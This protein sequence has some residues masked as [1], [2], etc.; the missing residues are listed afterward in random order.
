MREMKNTIDALNERE[1]CN[2]AKKKKYTPLSLLY[3]ELYPMW[4]CGCLTCVFGQ[5]MNM[6]LD[7]FIEFFK[8]IKL[9]ERRTII[10]H[11]N[12]YCG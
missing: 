10:F 4:L 9:S 5:F 6:K 3:R 12:K 11:E 7:Y 2:V 1:A 8:V